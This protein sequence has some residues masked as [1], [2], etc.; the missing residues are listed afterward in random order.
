[1][2]SEQQEKLNEAGAAAGEGVREIY[3]DD[4]I[5]YHVYFN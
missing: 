5:L 2:L 3:K 4:K 1:M